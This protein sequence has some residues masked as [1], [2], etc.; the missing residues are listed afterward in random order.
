MAKVSL[1]FP[2]P[3]S[4]STEY[5]ICLLLIKRQVPLSLDL[6]L[7]PTFRSWLLGYAHDAAGGPGAG[8]H[9]QPLSTSTTW[10]KWASPGTNTWSRTRV[11]AVRRAHQERDSGELSALTNFDSTYAPFILTDHEH[12]FRKAFDLQYLAKTIGNALQYHLYSFT[13]LTNQSSSCC[14]LRAR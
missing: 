6:W 3:I 14:S 12:F 7:L 8:R 9:H 10:P 2:S 4:G 1:P 13:S 11:C 5:S